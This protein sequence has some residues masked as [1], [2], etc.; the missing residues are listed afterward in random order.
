MCYNTCSVREKIVHLTIIH[1]MAL[2]KPAIFSIGGSTE[3]PWATLFHLAEEVFVF[4]RWVVIVLQ[5]KGQ[6][7]VVLVGVSTFGHF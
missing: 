3:F 4:L 2:R 7:V 5:A 1:D 6:V